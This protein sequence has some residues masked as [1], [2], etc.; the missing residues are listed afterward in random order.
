MGVF[1]WVAGVC[2]VV[3]LV[4]LVCCVMIVVGDVLVCGVLLLFFFVF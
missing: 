2:V 3:C 1:K 4:W